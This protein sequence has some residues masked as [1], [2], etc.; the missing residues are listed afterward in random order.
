V[1]LTF[2]EAARTGLFTKF[3]TFTGRARRSEYWWFSVVYVVGVIV[4]GGIA[5][6]LGQP[7]VWLAA[8][9][10]A[11]PML[12]VSVRRFHDMGQSGWRILINLIPVIGTIIYLVGMTRRGD[13]GTNAYGPAV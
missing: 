10:V 7:I 8:I 11:V 2:A 9:V 1:T 13:Q 4:V 5:I 6:A 3:A 12:A